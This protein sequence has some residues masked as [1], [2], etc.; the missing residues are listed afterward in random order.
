MGWAAAKSV[1]LLDVP[2]KA[3]KIIEDTISKVLLR[4]KYA[5]QRSKSFWMTLYIQLL[6]DRA[7]F[8]DGAGGHA[9]QALL[10]ARQL[11]SSPLIAH[12]QRFANQT[13]GVGAEALA[14]LN[15]SVERFQLIPEN[16]ED[17]LLLTPSRLGATLNRNTTALISSTSPVDPGRFEA[18]FLQTKEI[19]PS[20]SNIGMMASAAAVAAMIKGHKKRAVS[21]LEQASIER[22]LPIDGFNIR[23]NLLCAESNYAG[24][25]DERD[26]RAL[27]EDVRLFPFP[28]NWEYHRVRIASNL[29]TVATSPELKD[30]AW[31]VI[32]KNRFLADFDGW[33]DEAKLRNF[34]I[35]SRYTHYLVGGTLAGQFGRF[36]SRTGLF[37][38]I[39]KDWT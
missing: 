1:K 7:F 27:C 23:M 11:G 33:G 30:L 4:L 21:L 25:I 24:S 29:L 32:D 36:C 18:D 26:F 5:E 31:N 12:C 15:D 3:E 39:D 22:S 17:Y 10:L 38:C 28:V 16:S 2:D 8:A 13:L 34:L 9:Q 35:R 6:L 20:Y 19:F 14:V 37:P